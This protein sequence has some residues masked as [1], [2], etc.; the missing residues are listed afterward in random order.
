MILKQR[1]IIKNNFYYYE[2]FNELILK[3]SII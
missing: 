2:N 1:E 3:K